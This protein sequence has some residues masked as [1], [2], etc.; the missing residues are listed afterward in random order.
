MKWLNAD[1][2]E[3]VK[4]YWLGSDHIMTKLSSI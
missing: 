1:R 2:L 3:A 4:S